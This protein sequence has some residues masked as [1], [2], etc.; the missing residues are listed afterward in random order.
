[1]SFSMTMRR[2]EG[3]VGWLIVA[4]IFGLVGCQES[5]D[6]IPEAPQVL[7][8]S[9]AGSNITTLED[10]RPIEA[11][12]AALTW[13]DLPVAMKPCLTCHRDIVASYVGHGMS[14]SIGPAG[15]VTGGVVDNPISGNRYELRTDDGEPWLHA[16]LPDGGA[17]GQRIVGRIG[18]GVLDTSWVGE[19][20]DLHSG[21]P[22]GRLFF[23][24]VETISGHGLELSPF[25]LGEQ[26]I[27]LDLALTEGCLTCHTT[28]RLE[29]LP[30]ASTASTGAG[31]TVGEVFPAN[32]LGSDAFEHLSAL[33]CDACHGDSKRHVEWMTRANERPA[34]DV[35]LRRVG[36]LSAGVQRDICARCH[37]QGDARLDL[38]RANPDPEFP[39]AGQIPTLV[40]AAQ[41]VSDFRFVGQ[42][43]RLSLSACFDA[44]PGMTCTTCHQPHVGV[45]AQGTTS[46]DAVC[47]SCHELCSRPSDLEVMAITGEPARSEL[48]CTDCHIRRSQPFDLPHVRSA[49]HFIRRQIEKPATLPFRQFAKVGGSLEIYDDGRLE[50]LLATQ[51]GQRWRGGVLAM[52]LITVGRLSEAAELFDRFPAPGSAEAR[53]PSAPVGLVPVETYAGFHQMRALSYLATG[54]ADAAIAAF[55]DAL[56]LDPLLASAL[57]G[58]AQLRLDRG[59]LAGALADSQVVID[60]YPKAEHPWQLRATMAERLGRPAHAA[61]A[62]EAYVLQWPSNPT[63]WTKLGL[64]RRQAGNVQGAEEAM[65]RAQQLSPSLRLAGA[66][67]E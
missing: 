5:S 12:P 41:P 20:V 33:T 54:N 56:E 51:S 61:S 3:P 47:A 11:E 32:A 28:D 7:A 60:S 57:L 39:L 50:P 35:G 9:G 1:M 22:T 62:F 44:T 15:T 53:R 14:R 24:P 23:A 26:K 52:G 16:T 46:F 19:E 40:P 36:E 67:S 37:L 30:G 55:S 21:Q 2:A 64:L 6:R 29:H 42:L 48:G 43:E 10:G 17:R 45:A 63:V 66:V 25:D 8:V 4:S 31:D 27:G 65:V 38:V 59:D 58:R 13:A 49:D 18:A 34:G